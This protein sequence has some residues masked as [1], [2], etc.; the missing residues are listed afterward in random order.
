MEGRTCGVT[1]GKVVRRLAR[2]TTQCGVGYALKT[3]ARILLMTVDT[4]LGRRLAGRRESCDKHD[5][6]SG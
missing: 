6:D 5:R 1:S 2:P 3:L 4:S